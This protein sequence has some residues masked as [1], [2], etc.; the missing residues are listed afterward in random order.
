MKRLTVLAALLYA[1]A[2]LAGPAGPTQTAAAL[3]AR[4]PGLPHDAPAAFAQWILQDGALHEGPRDRVFIETVKRSALS[5][6]PGTGQQGQSLAA[7]YSTPEGQKKIA[8]MSLAEKMALARQ[9]APQPSAA[10]GGP[11]SAGDIARIKDVGLYPRTGEVRKRVVAIRM[12]VSALEAQWDKDRA[13]IDDAEHAEYRT[14]AICPGESGEPSGIAVRALRLKYDDKRIAL[15]SGYLPKFAPLVVQAKQAVM[16]EIVHGDRAVASWSRIS[17]SGRRSA[18][19]ATAQGARNIAFS[20]VAVPFG[21]VEDVSKKAAA[22][23]A[24][25]KRTEELYAHAGGC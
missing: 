14:L 20:D 4:S 1:G 19:H 16:P 11:V 15:A 5:P 17:D 6:L 9:M 24:D 12:K 10:P 13:R 2:A 8:A 23:V 21:I 25:R 22:S 7:Y 18:L 3:L